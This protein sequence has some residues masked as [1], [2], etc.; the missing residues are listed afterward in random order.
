MNFKLLLLFVSLTALLV[1]IEV[2]GQT[3]VNPA[4][5][6][7]NKLSDSQIDRIIQEI[8]SRGLSESQAIALAKAQGATDTQIDQLMIR[9]QQRQLSPSGST[10][11]Y[12]STDNLG[13]SNLQ[14]GSASRNMVSRKVMINATEKNKK[15]FGFQLFN[16]ENLSFE[17]SVNIPTPKNYTLGIGDQLTI[18]VW[19]ASQT[20]YQLKIDRNGSITIPDIGPVYLA[21]TSFEKAQTLLKDRLTAIYSGMSGDYPNTWAEVNLGMIRSI[22]VNVIGEINAPGTYNLPATASAFNALYLSGGPNEFGSFREIRVV[23]DG[24]TV[25]TI[26]VYDFLINADPSADFQLRDQDILFVPTFKTRVEMEGEIKRKGLFEVKSNETLSDL[27]RFAGG[28]TEN[29]FTHSLSLIRNTDKEKKIVDIAE[30]DFGTFQLQNG[31]IVRTDSILNRYANRVSISGAVFHAGNYELT[32]GLKL[33]DLIKKAD[34]VKEDAFLNRGL[35]A[36]LKEDHSLDNISFNLQEVLKGSEDMLLKKEDSVIIRSIFDMRE[37]WT[38]NIVGQVQKPQ[39][40]D[41]RDNMTLGDLIFMA[42]GFMENADVSTVEIS[43]RLTYDESAKITNKL[44]QI[45]QFSISRD[46]KLKP[47][48]A[49]FKLE[50]FDEVFVR[51]APGARMD[52]SVQITGEVAFAGT[53]SIFDKNERISDVIKRAGGL[54]PGAY[55]K[56]ATLIRTQQ[57]TTAEM[58]KKKQMLKMDTLITDSLKERLTYPVGIELDKIMANPGSNIDLLLQPDDM[59]NVPRELQTIK[60]SGSVLNPLALTYN[61]RNG[62]KEYISQAGGFSNNAKKSRLYVVY[63]NGSS[64][65][66]KGL[67]IKRYPK[68]TPGSEIIIPSKPEH[69]GGDNA[70]KWISIASMLSSLAVSVATVVS[71]TN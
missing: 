10:N 48:D 65:S 47:E 52:V 46:L 38:V 71:L 41:Y 6:D 20:T 36:R 51:R 23:R 14:T 44:K 60:I 32:E 63:P 31:D 30:S 5:V 39:K 69:V 58:E 3:P 62:V 9:I 45:Q 2:Q 56:G 42:G 64:A 12:Y 1:S 28:F 21:G 34:G 19:G 26:D 18:N 8:Q 27:L 54:I 50:P 7:V 16:S 17:P 61:K 59:I 57:L 70:M 68:V 66:T 43:R 4:S 55:P 22:K 37:K 67:I 40:F 33:S 49:L 53:Y 24:T 29:A 11:D 25:K 15:I 35:I 13:T